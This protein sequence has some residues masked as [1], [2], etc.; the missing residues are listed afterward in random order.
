VFWKHG[1]AATSVSELVEATGLSRSSLYQRFGDKDGLFREVLH[2]YRDRVVRRMEGVQAKSQKGRLEALLHDFV[3]R[4][5][6]ASRPPGCLL[7]R[8]CAEMGDIPAS[9][10]SAVESGVADQHRAIEGILRSAV[11]GGELSPSTDLNGLAWY[12][13]GVAQAIVN[14]PQAGASITATRQMIE[15][16]LSA[17]PAPR[18]RPR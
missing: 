3:P 6:K 4:A 9:S 7:A 15:F 12:F 5:G 2:R 18:A 16:A 14:L 17:W 13:L 10:K 1:Y 8:S 11:E